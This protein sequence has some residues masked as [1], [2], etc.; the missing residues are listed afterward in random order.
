MR[1]SQLTLTQACKLT[2][3]HVAFNQSIVGGLKT[4]WRI[5]MRTSHCANTSAYSNSAVSRNSVST[6]ILNFKLGTCFIQFG[7]KS[8][9]FHLDELSRLR[10]FRETLFGT[11]FVH[12]NFVNFQLFIYAK[13]SLSA[14]L[15]WH[16]MS[17]SAEMSKMAIGRY[18]KYTIKIIANIIR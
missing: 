8:F 2:N 1:R 5:S 18:E 14:I 13:S 7:M 6:V 11:D 16:K 9:Y 15:T 17:F 10:W 3:K 12:G 4:R